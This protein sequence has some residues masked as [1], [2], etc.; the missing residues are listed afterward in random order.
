MYSPNY[1]LFLT[2]L[3]YI[4]LIK[5]LQT[6]V[7]YTMKKIRITEAQLAKITGKQNINE[8]WK[9]KAKGLAAAGMLAA[10]VY[11]ASIDDGSNQPQGDINIPTKIEMA[12]QEIVNENPGVDEENVRS[13]FD[14]VENEGDFQNAKR[15]AEAHASDHMYTESRQKLDALIS[16]GISDYLKHIL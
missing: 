9:D 13:W 12:V 5:N 1:L 4:V 8:G 3:L 16:E 14:G 6:R 15:A 11:G 2:Y 7:F 10:G